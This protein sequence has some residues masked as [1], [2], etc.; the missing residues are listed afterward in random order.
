[1][2]KSFVAGAD[3]SEFANSSVQLSATSSRRTRKLFDYIENLKPCYCSRTDLLW[4]RIRFIRL[5]ILGTENAKWDY[6]KFHWV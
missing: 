5:V 3:I 6:Q 2:A 4:R 1:V